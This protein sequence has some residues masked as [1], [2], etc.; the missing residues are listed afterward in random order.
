[1]LRSALDNQWA[2]EQISEPKEACCTCAAGISGMRV[3]AM[4][5]LPVSLE[6]MLEPAIE[7][8]GPRDEGS[9]ELDERLIRS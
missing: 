2:P 3:V 6:L 1:M 4:L 7:S 9:S 8:P 5:D